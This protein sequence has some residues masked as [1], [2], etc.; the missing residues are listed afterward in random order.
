MD[1]AKEAVESLQTEFKNGAQ[2]MTRC[3]KPD[4]KE[5]FQ[6]CRAVATG[7]VI[8]GGIGYVVKLV[9]IPI[10]NILVGGS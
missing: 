4:K 10:N 6:I 8:M 3:T 1:V 7:F 5:Y 2:F 9:H